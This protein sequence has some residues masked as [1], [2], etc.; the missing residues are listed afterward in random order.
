MNLAVTVAV[1]IGIKITITMAFQLKRGISIVLAVE[2]QMRNKVYA[3]RCAKVR[4]RMKV[5]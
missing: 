2:E 5:L 3:K 4:R 1:T